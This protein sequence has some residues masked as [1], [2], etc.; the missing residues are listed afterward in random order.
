MRDRSLRGRRRPPRVGGAAVCVVV[1]L[2]G[3]LAVRHFVAQPFVVPSSSMNPILREGDVV[4]AD[5]SG[6]GQAVRG[7]VV[8]FDGSGYFGPT[9]GGGAFWVKRVIAVGGDR[10]SCCDADGAL[11]VNGESLAEPYLAP[12]IAPSEVEFDLEVPAGRM[13]VL[14]DNRGDSTDSRFLLGAP[15][16]GMIPVERVVGPVKRVIWPLSRAGHIP[17]AGRA[18]KMPDDD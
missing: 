1:L 8:V 11:L 10:V 17:Y 15:G 4:L 16:G 14:G 6:R 9:D 12:G 18:D 7:Q 2:L 13:F 3:A 5:R